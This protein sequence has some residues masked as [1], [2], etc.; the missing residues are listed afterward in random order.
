MKK[1]KLI[2]MLNALD[3]DPEIKIWNGYVGDFM[4]L[5]P[6]PVPVRL[7]KMTESYLLEMVRLEQCIDAGADRTTFKLS[8]AE[9]ADTKRCYKQYHDWEHNQFV[10]DEDIKKKS[11]KA[12]TVI[13]LNPKPRGKNSFDRIG[14]ISY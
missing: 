10:T 12:Q 3:G 6:T 14:T 13:M 5:D 8:D 7:V 11:Y 1:S 9:I 2:E 4:D